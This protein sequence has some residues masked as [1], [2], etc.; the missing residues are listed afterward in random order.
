[1]AVPTLSTTTFDVYWVGLQM[2]AD[3]RGGQSEIIMTLRVKKKAQQGNNNETQDITFDRNDYEKLI[4][5]GV[6]PNLGTDYGTFVAAVR[7]APWQETARLR[8]V[9]YGHVSQ[10]GIIEIVLRFATLYQVNPLTFPDT[11][12]GANPEVI[13]LPGAI[14]LTSGLR[15][16]EAFRR[17]WA[18]N[19]P[20][21]TVTDITSDIGGLPY[22]T[23]TK[24]MIIEVPQT[25]ARVRWI[26]DASVTGMLA[27]YA[28]VEPYIN[29]MNSQ[30]FLGFPAG[31]L[32]CEGI[33]MVHL[34]HEYYELVFDFTYDRFYHFSQQA[35]VHVNGQV[36]LVNGAPKTVK[37]VRQ[38]RTAA[39]FNLLFSSATP[40]STSLTYT[41][42]AQKNTITKGWWST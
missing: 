38:T 41:E 18:T 19:P 4:I 6:V 5:E 3:D 23:Q 36:Q 2:K 35:D 9:N 34:Q 11:V 39:D 24:G 1:M 42:T 30:T 15:P 27:Q 31:S 21:G 7:E 17:F 25:R 37:W 8:E 12:N 16:M 29:T 22:A 33:N 40:P 20:T 13:D 28:K 14:E 10:N 26:L 32:V